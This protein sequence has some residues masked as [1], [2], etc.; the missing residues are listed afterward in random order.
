MV[1]II[2]VS[3]A[4]FLSFILITKKGKN[5]ADKVLLGWLIIIGLHLSLYYVHISSPYI[6]Y[7][8]LFGVAIPF[9]ILHGPFLFL[10]TM[11]LTNPNYFKNYRWFWHFMPALLMYVYLLPFF[12]LSADKKLEVIRNEGA[13][14][15]AFT[16]VSIILFII[17]GFGYVIWSSILLQKHKKNINQQF[18]NTERINLKWLQYLI[19]CLGITWLFVVWGNDD[20][21]FAAAS[22]FVLFIGYFGIKQVGIFTNT[23]LIAPPQYFTDLTMQNALIDMPIETEVIESEDVIKKKYQKS[24]LSEGQAEKVQKELADIMQTEKLYKNPELTLADLANRLAIH[25]NYLSQ[26]INEKEGV[27]FYDYV[28]NLR[29]E[30]FKKQIVLPQ[31]KQYTLLTVAYDCGFNSKSSFNRYFK[32][33]MDVQ[34]S[35][36]VRSLN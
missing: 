8:H 3:I 1:Y 23:A 27:N 5:I 34:P 17:S 2:G 36:Y 35:E 7:P 11:A 15:A 20:W 29:I 32:K 22:V 30:E 31:N 19:Y 25:P 28:N 4:W 24:G 21:I 14:Y 12:I 13:D 33:V 9:P 16:F 18:S 26:V 10:Y 6:Q